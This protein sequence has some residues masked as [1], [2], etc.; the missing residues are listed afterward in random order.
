MPGMDT[1]MLPA[2]P[3]GPARFTASSRQETC[4]GLVHHHSV[5]SVRHSINPVRC[6]DSLRHLSF[7]RGDEEEVFRSAHRGDAICRHSGSRG[8]YLYSAFGCGSYVVPIEK[9]GISSVCGGVCV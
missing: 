4:V 1:S 3:I 8:H 6:M 9:D 7:Y 5:Y 2:Q